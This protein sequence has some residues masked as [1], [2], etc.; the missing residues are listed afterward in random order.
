MREGGTRRDTCAAY[1]DRRRGLQP[2]RRQ[3]APARFKVGDHVKVRAHG[4]DVE[5]CGTVASA[6][7]AIVGGRFAYGVMYDDHTPQ[8]VRPFGSAG[9]S[10]GE[11]DLEPVP[12]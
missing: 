6:F 9:H 3:T 11:R 12:A 7:E 5:L 2:M 8:D 4:G 10:Y 1:P